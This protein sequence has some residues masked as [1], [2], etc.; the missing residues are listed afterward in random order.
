MGSNKL[1]MVKCEKF[2]NKH[3][4]NKH[5]EKSVNSLVIV[6]RQISISTASALLQ[7]VSSNSKFERSNY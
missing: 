3:V 2:R 4:P 1:E 5:T 7:I 6:L